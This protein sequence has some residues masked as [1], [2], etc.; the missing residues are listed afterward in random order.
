[1]EIYRINTICW[2][3]PEKD[4]QGVF[5]TEYSAKNY[6]E[7]EIQNLNEELFLISIEKAEIPAWHMREFRNWLLYGAGNLEDLDLKWETTEIT[8]SKILAEHAGI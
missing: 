5:L 3:N 2:S 6:Y 1:M 7:T 4:N 8:S